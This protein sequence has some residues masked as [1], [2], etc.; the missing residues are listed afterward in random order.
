M[1]A[2]ETLRYMQSRQGLCA[3]RDYLSAALHLDAQIAVK[4]ARADALRARR[5][6]LCAG[7]TQQAL[8]A[9]E[10]EIQADYASL[11]R[12][13]RQIDAVIRSVPEDMSRLV[14][15]CRYLQ[16]LPFFR[17]AMELHYDERQIYRYHRKGLMYVAARL[18][19]GLTE[20]AD[21]RGLLQPPDP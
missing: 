20:S 1:T 16:G 4:Q 10:Q 13:Q 18:A 2:Q 8:D 17:I 21:C 14:L 19:Q 5:S 9:L 11:F 15:E 3:A 6:L 7:E 12:R